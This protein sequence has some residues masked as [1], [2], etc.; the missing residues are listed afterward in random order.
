ML[1]PDTA[2]L[3]QRQ[4]Y[5][6]IGAHSGVKLCHWTKQSLKHDRGCYKQHFYGID[7]HR[8]MQMTP[9]VNNCNLGCLFCWRDQSHW[10]EGLGQVDDPDFILEESLV[11]QG[12]LL[13]GYKGNPLV[14][15]DKWME[16]NEVRH[17]AISLTGEPSLYPK[18][19]EFLA[20]CHRKGLTTF[21]VTNG[22]NP[23][24]LA[25]LDPL[26]TQLYVTVAAPNEAIYE[27]LCLPHSHHEWRNLMETLDLLPSLDTRR[28]IRHSLVDGYNVGWEEEYAA[29]D[30]RS[31][32]E[33]IECKG[34][35][36]VG[37][38]RERLTRGNMPSHRCIRAFATRLAEEVGYDFRDEVEV[39]RV[40]L[41]TKPGVEPRIA[42]LV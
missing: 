39:S 5:K 17:V 41:L 42:A 6:L 18:L 14:D 30:G 22:T 11:A 29:L 21:L 35:V 23:K 33:F 38:S 28:V 15:L 8:C 20:A 32:A 13:S 36:W 10:G 40:V 7:S 4:G 34:Y 16:A 1:D 37:Q 3:L 19:A 9:T 24:V 27:A 31:E 12:A 26:P 25:D 2:A